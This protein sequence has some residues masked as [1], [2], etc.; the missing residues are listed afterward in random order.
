MLCLY[1]LSSG[2]AASSLS[3][4]LAKSAVTS[5]RL[6]AAPVASE[7]ATDRTPDVSAAAQQILQPDTPV[8]DHVR[9]WLPDAPLLPTP[10]HGGCMVDVHTLETG[11][12]VV[13]S[14]EDG[15]FIDESSVVLDSP[16]V[17]AGGLSN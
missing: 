15:I 2:L 8:V 4:A 14:A 1:Q 11:E 5:P 16:V 12:C 7:A 6:A 17:Q 9:D 3:N 10:F 13:P